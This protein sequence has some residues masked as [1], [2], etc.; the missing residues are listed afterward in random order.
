MISWSSSRAAQVQSLHRFVENQQ[1]RLGEQGLRQRESLDHPLAE[2]GDRFM[3]AVGQL[4]PLE[5]H[6][7]AG[8]AGPRAKSPPGAP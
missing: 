7:H 8:R 3:G 1:F 6:G 2:A 5:E 4:Q